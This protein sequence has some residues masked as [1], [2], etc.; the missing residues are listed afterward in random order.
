MVP[1]GGPTS[2]GTRLE[3]HYI[4]GETEEEI[5]KKM[6]GNNLALTIKP[7]RMAVIQAAFPY[8]AQLE[9]YRIALRYK[10]I[11]EL[12]AHPEDMP[13]FNGVEVQRRL[14][15][16]K[17]EP[18]EDWSNLDY[19]GDSQDLR[20]IKLDIDRDESSD[21]QRV[22]LHE[23]NLLVMPLPIEVTGRYPEMKMQVLRDAIEK[24]KRANATANL[25]APKNR[26]AGE[27]KNPFGRN[28]GTN[29]QKFNNF[30]PGGGGAG[31]ES[32]V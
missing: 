23:D 4:Y 30:G 29:T 6:M 2:S 16:L 5:E 27:D 28:K 8:R 10:D 17:G 22:M 24:L 25:P 32:C 21:I 18:L 15:N 14:F 26:F 9:R 31:G 1:F 7:E 19:V 12:Y 11:K 3:V 13:V 20:A